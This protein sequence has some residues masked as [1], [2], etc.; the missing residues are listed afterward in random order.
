LL[1]CAIIDPALRLLRKFYQF[2]LM[3]NQAAAGGPARSVT[4]NEP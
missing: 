3:K 2:R 1:F 4:N